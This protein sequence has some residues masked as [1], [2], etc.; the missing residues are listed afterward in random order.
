MTHNGVARGGQCLL[1]VYSDHLCDWPR[2]CG[3]AS[4]GH[5]QAYR[6]IRFT[7]KWQRKCASYIGHSQIDAPGK[8]WHGG[9]IHA[10]LMGC[11]R[12]H[13]PDREGQVD[14]GMATGASLA[15]L[16]AWL[17]DPAQSGKK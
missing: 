5:D 6:V 11:G 17:A 1:H 13:G 12:S 2:R 4:V 9:V 7:G 14:T 8:P 16:E 15:A 10:F 3:R